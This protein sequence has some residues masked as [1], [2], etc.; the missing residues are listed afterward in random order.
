M[1][2]LHTYD[3][4]NLLAKEITTTMTSEVGFELTPPGETAA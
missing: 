4:P 3:Q 1:L 2:L